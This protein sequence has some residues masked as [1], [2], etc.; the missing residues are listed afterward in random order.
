MSIA[1][2][3]VCPSRGVMLGLGKRL[4]DSERVIGFSVGD[5]LTSEDAERTAALWRFLADTA[6]EELVVKFSVDEEFETIAEYREIGGDRVDDIPFEV[7]LR[8]SR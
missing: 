5:H 7:Y 3:L 6:G 8:D 1:S 2:Y 4:R